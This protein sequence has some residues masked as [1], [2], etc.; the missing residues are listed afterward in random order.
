ML[1]KIF[2]KADELSDAAQE[3]PE[4][5]SKVIVAM[6]IR[7]KAEHFMITQINDQE[8]VDG[9]VSNQTR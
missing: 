7:L 6:A 4:L 1:D 3:S 8:F 5:E 9:I 2:Q